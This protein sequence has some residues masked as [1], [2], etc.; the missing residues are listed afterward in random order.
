MPSTTSGRSVHR[1]SSPEKS[2]YSLDSPAQVESPR[3]W[4]MVGSLSQAGTFAPVPGAWTGVYGNE[5][6]STFFAPSRSSKGRP[7]AS[8]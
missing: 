5:S 4:Y 7:S 8:R 3:L 1:S 2:P 6:R